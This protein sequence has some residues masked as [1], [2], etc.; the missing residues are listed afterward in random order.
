MTKQS[1]EDFQGTE[2]TLYDTIMINIRHYTCV[3][4]HRMFNTK[5]EHL[6]KLWTLD[7]YN[8]PMQVHPSLKKMYATG[9]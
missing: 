6:G 7:D 3:Q 1:T 4:T 5:S 8:V 2:N 9:K